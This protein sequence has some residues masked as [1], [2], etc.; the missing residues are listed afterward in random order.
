VVVE[1]A[2]PDVP[3]PFRDDAVTPAL[4][5]SCREVGKVPAAIARCDVVH[6]GR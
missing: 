6:D 4:L 2:T 5:G 1:E 3:K